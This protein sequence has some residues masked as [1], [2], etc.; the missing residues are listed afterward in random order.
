MQ[1]SE[2]LGFHAISIVLKGYLVQK[3][4]PKPTLQS[5][6]ANQPNVYKLPR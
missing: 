1:N 2:L 4:L 6:C 5:T 3:E